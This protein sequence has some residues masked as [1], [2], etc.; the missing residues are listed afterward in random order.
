M[1]M[2]HPIEAQALLNASA[3]LSNFRRRSSALTQSVMSCR[4]M[5][6]LIVMV[7]EGRA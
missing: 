2:P 6:Y 3:S 4:E 1:T 5:I 7:G